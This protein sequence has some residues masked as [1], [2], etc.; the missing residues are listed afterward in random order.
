MTK[1]VKKKKHNNRNHPYSKP[2][3]LN[4]LDKLCK[5][6]NYLKLDHT[7]NSEELD[8]N[9]ILNPINL[10]INTIDNQIS[11]IVQIEQLK[12]TVLNIQMNSF[13]IVDQVDTQRT[14]HQVDIQRQD[15][16]VDTQRTNHQIIYQVDIQRQDYQ[17]IDQ[18]DFQRQDYQIIDQID[19]REIT[20]ELIR[21]PI[22]QN[23]NTNIFGFHNLFIGS[24][25]SII[26][27]NE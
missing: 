11:D 20:E 25:F 2:N 19:F 18:I 7:L 15:Y 13:N 27:T 3:N 26:D 14:N 5:N 10:E 4:L 8:L 24:N 17:I 16:Q 12:K 9:K 6:F 21:L 23:I 22:N 1:S